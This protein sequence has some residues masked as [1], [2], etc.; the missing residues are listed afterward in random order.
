MFPG[1]LAGR[2]LYHHDH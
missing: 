2:Q 1:T